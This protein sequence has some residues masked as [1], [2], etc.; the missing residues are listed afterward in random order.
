MQ[1]CQHLGS[2]CC[3]AVA[4]MSCVLCDV[5]VFEVGLSCRTY[6]LATKEQSG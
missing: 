4:L 6:F 1:I 2:A 5:L 3:L